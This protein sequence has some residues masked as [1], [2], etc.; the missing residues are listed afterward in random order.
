MISCSPF[1]KYMHNI[2]LHLSMQLMTARQCKLN[3]STSA[4]GP[5][6]FSK[7]WLRLS[8]EFHLGRLTCQSLSLLYFLV[9]RTKLRSSAVL[10]WQVRTAVTESD[11]P[12]QHYLLT[13]FH[14]VTSVYLIWFHDFGEREHC[15][16]PVWLQPSLAKLN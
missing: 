13:H 10:R 9:I 3:S 6:A 7:Q 16:I 12:R 2:C 11:T 4:T 15:F 1:H 14:V 5:V 8:P